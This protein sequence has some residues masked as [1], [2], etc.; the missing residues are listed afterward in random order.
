MPNSYF[1]FK[2]FIIHQD[3]CAMK[4]CTDACILGAWFP[5]KIPAYSRILDIGSGTG[6]LTLMMAQKNKGEIHGVE[7][8]AASFKQLKE[9][10][11]KSRW[12]GRI[13]M[14][15]GD[16]RDFVFP[17][18][19]DFIIANPPFFEGDLNSSSIPKNLAMHSSELTLSELIRVV[20]ANLEGAG[21]FGILLPYHRTRYFEEMAASHHFYLREKLLVRQTP[22]HDFF[23]SILHFSRHP[24]HFVPVTKM[25]IKNGAGDYA[26]KFRELLADYYLYL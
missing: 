22:G 16:A 14:F 5:E 15:P 25:S 18:K 9:N 6:L 23:R 24:G 19:Y 10:I 21:S 8:D 2:E 4:V 1:Q 11:A 17:N 12:E 13:R 26:D 3:Q 20:D 7:L